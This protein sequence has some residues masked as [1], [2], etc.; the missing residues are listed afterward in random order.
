LITIKPNGEMPAPG[1]PD[2]EQGDGGLN[3]TIAIVLVVAAGAALLQAALLRGIAIGVEA[4]AAP[5]YLPKVANALNPLFG[6]TIRR[7]HKLAETTKEV[8]AEAYEQVND[9]VAEVKAE[10]DALGK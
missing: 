10:T 3:V 4:V 2:V 9:V 5:K 7:T 6:S 1:E 8:F